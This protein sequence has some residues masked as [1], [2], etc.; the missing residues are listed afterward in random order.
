[1]PNKIS[2]NID[3]K[4]QQQPASEP[5]YNPLDEAVNEK[6]YTN[7]NVNPVGVD[8]TKSIDE[9]T[10]TPP[11]FQKKQPTTNDAGL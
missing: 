4:P 2:E 3:I 6:K 9:P 8:F 5:D 10:F 11:P 7:P 1:M